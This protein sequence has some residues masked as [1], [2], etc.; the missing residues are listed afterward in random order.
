MSAQKTKKP[1]SV[2]LFGSLPPAVAAFM[3]ILIVAVIIFSGTIASL[4]A[5]DTV[6]PASTHARPH[7]DSST[8]DVYT[9]PY[10]SDDPAYLPTDAEFAVLQT[11]FT[12]FLQA[13][14]ISPYLYI[15]HAS[16]DAL[17]SFAQITYED[18]FGTHTGSLL[19]IRTVD[20]EGKS[21]YYVYA[22]DDTV[23]DAEA[24]QILSA[25]LAYRTAE[26]DTY[27]NAVASALHMT[28]ERIMQKTP[29][30]TTAEGQ[31]IILLATAVLLVVVTVLSSVLQK[32]RSAE[33][34]ASLAAEATADA[35]PVAAFSP[36]LSDGKGKEAR[37]S[38]Q[39]GPTASPAETSIS[40]TPGAETDDAETDDTAQTD[41][42]CPD[43][44]DTSSDGPNER[45]SRT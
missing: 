4:F 45:S 40:Q 37:T 1:F 15:T 38:V 43:A 8:T 14:G 27:S 22:P 26:G 31:V 11:A 19:L 44:A 2:T 35:S 21:T 6:A 16:G 17:P 28:A 42:A 10:A 23:M 32:K 12:D 41:T 36:D 29:G 25:Y 33:G 24:E 39:A 9:A 13:T 3:V 5:N 30:L 7:Y 34:S 18:L 20:N